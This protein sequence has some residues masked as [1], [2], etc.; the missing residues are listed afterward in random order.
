MSLRGMS[1]CRD[2]SCANGTRFIEDARASLVKQIIA[3]MFLDGRELATIANQ[4]L[5][6]AFSDD[7]GTRVISIVHFSWMNRS[8]QA[9]NAFMKKRRTKWL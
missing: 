2:G 1:G 7:R 9:L 3:R 8:A 6:V 4:D 5:P